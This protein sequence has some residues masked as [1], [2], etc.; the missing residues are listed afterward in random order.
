MAGLCIVL[1]SWG[2]VVWGV[3]IDAVMLCGL[4]GCMVIVARC[5]RCCVLCGAAVGWGGL[6]L[7][8]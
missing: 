7:V 4:W 1:G 8:Y 2:V 5:G 3:R 6:V